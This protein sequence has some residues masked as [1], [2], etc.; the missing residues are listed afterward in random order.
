MNNNDYA[1]LI[2]KASEKIKEL[3]QKLNESQSDC[4]IAVLGYSCRFP[5]GADN[6]EQYWEL[7]KQGYD[8]VID[9]PEERFH[10]AEYYD[11]LRGKTGKTYTKEA[12]FLTC[13]IK[14]F[15][16]IHF[17]MSELEATSIDPQHRMLLEVTWEA[18]ENSG[19]N[20]KKTRGSK[21]GVYIGLISSEYGMSEVASDSP[22]KITP[23]SLM[24]N[25]INSAAGRISYY[26]DFKGP[27]MAIDTAC[28]SSMSA[29]NE[30]V[31]ALKTHQ[32]DMAIVGGAN[33]LLTPNGFVGLSQ[34]GAISEDGRCR[35]FDSDARGYGRSEGCGVV[36]LKRLSDAESD[37]D[38]IQAVVKSVKVMHGGKSNGFFAPNGLQEQAVMQQALQDSGLSIEDIDYIEA[39]GTGTVL[40]DAIEA[41]AISGVYA[42][43]QKDILIGSV[44]TNIGHM[45]A[46]AGMASLIKVLLSMKYGMIPANI[47][48]NNPNQECMYPHLKVVD[49][50][51][52]WKVSGHP[53]AA[54]ISSFGISGTLS[55]AIL[56][57]Y[58]N[59]KKHE[60]STLNVTEE[61]F[62]FSAL[63]KQALIGSLEDLADELNGLY[64]DKSFRNLA[65]MSNLTRSSLNSRFAAIVHSKDELYS[66]LKNIHDDSMGLQ[67]YSDHSVDIDECSLIFAPMN[68][69]KLIQDD[70]VK[71]LMAMSSAFKKTFLEFE[72]QIRSQCDISVFDW[73]YGHRTS[74]GGSCRVLLPLMVHCAFFSMLKSLL[75]VFGNYEAKG[76]GWLSL[77]YV[78]GA[79]RLSD[80]TAVAIALENDEQAKAK[81]LLKNA[82]IKVCHPAMVSV[83]NVCDIENP[84]TLFN[85]ILS[86]DESFA[87][88]PEWIM[89]LGELT[90]SNVSAGFDGSNGSALEC[91]KQIYLS[92]MPVNWHRWNDIFSHPVHEQP[93]LPGY[94]FNRKLC[95]HEPVY[96][97]GSSP[98]NAE[99]HV[100]NNNTQNNISLDNLKDFLIREVAQVSGIEPEDVET[101]KELSVYGFESIS[102]F[103]LSSILEQNFNLVVQ[104]EDF[105]GKLN[106]IDTIYEFVSSNYAQTAQLGAEDTQTSDSEILDEYPMSTMQARIFAEHMAKDSVLYD[107][108]GAYII[109]DDIDLELLERCANKM[110][111]RH[112][113]LSM[114]LIM[115]HGKFCMKYMPDRHLKIETINQ[116]ENMPLQEC[117]RNNLKHFQMDNPPLMEILVIETQDDKRVIV[118]HF[119]H[120]VSDGV[121]MNLYASEIM[122]MYFGDAL[123]AQPMQYWDYVAREKDYLE[124]SKKEEDCSFWCD[125]LADSIYK[126]SLPMDFPDRSNDMSGDAVL[127]VIDKELMQKIRQLCSVNR[128]SPFVFFMACTELLLHRLTFE[129]NIALAVPVSCRSSEFMNSVGMF[130]NTVAVPSRYDREITFVQMLQN[131]AAFT[132]QMM[133]HIVYPYDLLAQNLGISPENALNVMFVYENTNLR[134]HF[135]K[136]SAFVPFNYESNKEPFDLNF[137]LMEHND[138]VDIHLRYRTAVF[139]R[140]T[141]QRFAE[142]YKLLISTVAE[143]PEIIVGRLNLLSETEM[144]L[145]QKWSQGEVLSYDKQSIPDMFEKQ[146]L[147]NGER[148][149]VCD[150][151]EEITY[152]ALHDDAI[153]IA[154]ALVKQGIVHGDVVGLYL[155]PGVNMIRAILGVLYSGAAYLPIAHD[156]PKERRDYILLDSCAK[157]LISDSISDAEVRP[158]YD[159]STLLHMESDAGLKQLSSDSLA[160]IIYTSGT[161]GQ[162][163]GVLVEHDGI[164]NLREYF[165]HVHHVSNED[166]V[167]QFASYAFD[168][169]L[170]ELCMSIFSGGTLYIVP[171]EIRTDPVKLEDFIL[172]HQITICVLPPI[173]LQNLQPEKLSSLRTVITAGAETT[174]QIVQKFDNIEIYSND[175]GPTETSVCATFWKHNHTDTVPNRI[176]IGRPMCNKQIYILN[177]D[178]LCNQGLPGEL[179]IAGDG[180]AR[181]YIG[182][183]EQTKQKFVKCPFSDGRMYRT[184]DVARWLP[185]G[186]IEFHGRIDNQ[187][188]L[189]GYRIELGEIE[190]VASSIHGIVSCVV[191]V[192]KDTNNEDAL[193]MYYVSDSSLQSIDIYPEMQAKLPNYMLPSYYIEMKNFP[194][195]RSGKVDKALLPKPGTKR[196]NSYIAPTTET[197]K[198]ICELMEEILHFSPIGITDSFY[199]NGGQ[200]L[201]SMVLINHISERFGT[202]LP[203]STIKENPTP[204]KLAALVD[205]GYGKKAEII[206][207]AQEKES[208]ELG[209]AQKRIY[210]VTNITPDGIAYNMPQ[211]LRLKGAVKVDR[212]RQAVQDIV[213]ANSVLR[214]SFQLV[215]GKP[216]QLILPSLKLEI[217]ELDVSIEDIQMQMEAFVRPFDLSNPPLFRMLLLHTSDAD[218]LLM[219]FHHI[220]CDGMSLLNFSREFVRRYNGEQVEAP[221]LQFV[222]Y[223]EWSNTRDISNQGKYWKNVFE[224]IPEALNLPTDYVRP[225]EMSYRGDKV[226]LML[227]QEDTALIDQFATQRNTTPY[228]IFLSA[229]MILLNRY[230]GGK[231]DIVIGSPISGR[232][233]AETLKMFGMFVN[234]LAIRSNV[235]DDISFD[236]FLKEIDDTCIKAYE[237]Q[238]YP[239]DRLINDLSLGGNMMGNPLFDVMLAF[240]NNEQLEERFNDLE[241]EVVPFYSNSTK[242]EL[243]WNV[244]KSKDCYQ[245]DLEYC[246][247]LFSKMTAERMEKH[248]VYLM[249]L[250]LRNPE[251]HLAEYELILPEEKEMLFEMNHTFAEQ[252]EAT[253]PALFDIQVNQRNTADAIVFGDCRISYND[254]NQVSNDLAWK[255]HQL[256]IGKGDFVAIMADHGIEFF[257]AVLGVL[258]TGAA[259]IPIDP[260]LPEER[261]QYI[262]SDSKPKVLL[263]FCKTAFDSDSV[264]VKQLAAIQNW[265]KQE[266]AP[267]VEISVHDLAYCI[268][269]S[270]TTGNPKGVLLAHIGISTLLSYFQR[271]HGIGASDR[272]LQFANYSFDASVSEMTMGI[273]SGATMYIVPDDIKNNFDQMSKFIADK[274]ITAGILPPH[275]AVHVNLDGMRLVITAGSESSQAV[276]EHCS[277]N[278]YSNDYGPTE[279]TVCATFWKHKSGD[280]LP[281]RIPIGCPLSNKQVYVMNGMT[282]C[283]CNVPGELCVGGTGLAIGYLNMPD[284]TKEKFVINPQNGQRMYRTGDLARMLPDGNIDYLGRIDNQVKIRGF[285]VELGEIE[286]VLRKCDAVDDCTVTV[287]KKNV[288]SPAITAYIVAKKDLTEAELR[289]LVEKSLPDYMLPTYYVFIDSIPFN[290]SNKVNLDLLPDPVVTMEEY[291][292]PENE[293]ESAICQSFKQ[294]LG[295]DEIGRNDSFFQ[296]G[297]DS[298]M[299][300]SVVS[301]LENM[302]FSVTY[303]DVMMYR[304][305]A[306]IA[307][308]TKPTEVNH[309]GFDEV[310]GQV[311]NTPMLQMFRKW[312]LA[313]PEQFDQSAVFKLDTDCSDYLEEA[314]SILMKHHDILR[315]VYLDGVLTIRKVEEAQNIELYEY[316]LQDSGTVEQDIVKRCA[317]LQKSFVLE[318]GPLFKAAFF[319]TPSECYLMLCAHH[320]VIDRVS[321]NII[322]E[323]LKTCIDSLMLGKMPQLTNK[324]ASMIH[325]EQYLKE[326]L[327]TEQCHSQANYW[328]NIADKAQHWRF[329]S[330]S[331]EENGRGKRTEIL[332][333]TLTHLLLTECFNAYHAQVSELIIA[334]ISV[335]VKRVGG[336]DEMVLLLEKTGRQDLHRRFNLS[337]SVGWFTNTYPVIIPCCDELEQ[338][339]ILSKDVQRDVPDSGMAFSLCEAEKCSTDYSIS[340]NYLG[341]LNFNSH[342]SE[343]SSMVTENDISENNVFETDIAISGSVVGEK[344]RLS[345]SYDKGT[346]SSGQME[347]FGQTILEAL[348][349][350]ILL[351]SNNKESHST[352]SD[353]AETGIGQ[354]EFDEIMGMSFV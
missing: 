167:I 94:H 164:V 30:A 125:A 57:E 160:Y 198:V 181:G 177:G 9:I 83:D 75:P 55:H 179:C 91:M 316:Y 250:L 66:L 277:K 186:N 260:E 56:Q 332:D 253:I 169:I 109:E 120:A 99:A 22:Y 276:V 347:Q 229:L 63:T 205:H 130:T 32:C 207:P 102:F 73:V 352:K 42:K 351:C 298:I 12:A 328:R 203:Y 238:D 281:S 338:A 161:T 240:Q 13:D 129:D 6:P 165:R 267:P 150:E 101:D 234:T 59:E 60:I 54:G 239:F 346:H 206:T 275:Y 214:T 324:T 118:F 217:P 143:K 345:L 199:E 315:A 61:L 264:E 350:I 45:E 326:Y 342:F 235:K 336:L 210:S 228:V 266:T 305:P 216:R 113:V 69:E 166:R 226:S 168:A 218:F 148:I 213:D 209:Y 153:R 159:L 187:I 171:S 337:R 268:Y 193:V 263:K 236:A 265:E 208:Y 176:P 221:Q 256:E 299:A 308:Y 163:K 339:I 145:I 270:G 312:N 327:Q 103:K 180:I 77:A 107:L 322:A 202:E 92:G 34:V 353:I 31:V 288:S 70:Q 25:Y 147:K 17:E 154:K 224:D 85:H 191:T 89:F 137:E 313:T 293:V 190:A 64:K 269:T 201:R 123:S 197:E 105:Y 23:Y 278:T 283:G 344:L 241:A 330:D 80:V 243:T 333:E 10:V 74:V 178:A 348:K 93:I 128:M 318:E 204:Q 291:Q 182:L 100:K 4:D 131:A 58:C 136:Q 14:S 115:H 215:D 133:R 325:W 35:A 50:L 48:Y 246:V 258:K 96:F 232:T 323:D 249:Q 255:L 310:Y 65:Y 284:L 286:Q 155:H 141:V 321:W 90:Q 244:E 95:W 282:L 24:G 52:E 144:G 78:T 183:P 44:K 274:D 311:N 295:I 195:N 151:N 122:R 79:M 3:T 259:Y 1:L 53:R 72:N 15:D 146:V 304:T 262:L 88:W 273:L 212:I 222:D 290:R 175:Y 303:H 104:N 158:A 33:L 279:V 343:I 5:G 174:K 19:V 36:V 38:N 317:V 8:A 192:S 247:D 97:G 257:A 16:N 152:S 29:L 157:L 67:H 220:I 307:L 28:S 106:C 51:L 149:A 294:T 170:S 108:V 117:I 126:L 7:L 112:K 335:A 194:L 111:Q 233:Q 40:G 189:R 135:S 223:C 319:K 71:W 81:E 334:A 297:G 252:L 302:G 309:Y 156:C 116:P 139:E 162:P 49:Q 21:T 47:H 62:T 231:K 138:T 242:F 341:I 87:K 11:P 46:A 110:L 172:R 245:I 68:A 300:I 43:R 272:T 140:S 185:D 306:K 211:I 26:F 188:K 296:L 84:E 86:E 37:N 287:Y 292:A 121:S 127:S 119:H 230:S 134:S 39:H 196:N 248:F 76:I 20:I 237:N 142:M 227:S 331:S 280:E 41:K 82:K 200:S 225:K 18:L 329:P 254:L 173:V 251:R 114:A 349:N 261:I 320:L 301:K 98:L 219:D 132:N 271:E 285:R 354:T 27:C 2:K 340:F 124:S 184:G 314:I 289:R